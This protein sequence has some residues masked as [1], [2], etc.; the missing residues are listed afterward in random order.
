MSEEEEIEEEAEEKEEAKEGKEGEEEKPEERR[1]EV[2]IKDY[3]AFKPCSVCG[4]AKVPY[5]EIEFNGIVERTCKDCY[6]AQYTPKLKLRCPSCSS[7]CVEEDNFCWK[8]GF[9]L[10]LICPTCGSKGDI[11]DKFCRQC[12]GRL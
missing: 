9:R 12:G 6:E 4:E 3:S 11:G 8:C 2:K 10:H 1:E 7:E 5:I